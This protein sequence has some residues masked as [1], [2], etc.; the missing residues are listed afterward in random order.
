MSVFS[1]IS[2]KQFVRC[3]CNCDFTGDGFNCVLIDPC[4]VV[5][6]HANATCTP[7]KT[8]L[9]ITKILS[10]LMLSLFQMGCAC[11]TVASM[12]ME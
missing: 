1:S 7:G 6:C 9:T 8:T 11:A 4:S 5:T 10:P 2:D 3:T 12:G